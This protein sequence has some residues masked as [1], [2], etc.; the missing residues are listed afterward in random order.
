[1]EIQVTKANLAA[2]QKAHEV[3]DLLA[4]IQILN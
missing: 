3:N 2:P 4:N 1:M